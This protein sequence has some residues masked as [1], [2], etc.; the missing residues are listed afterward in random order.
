MNH[1][2]IMLLVEDRFSTCVLARARQWADGAGDRVVGL[3]VLDSLV[4]QSA[5]LQAPHPW[6][7]PATRACKRKQ[8]RVAAV[9]AARAA[10]RRSASSTLTLRYSCC[11]TRGGSF[12]RAPRAA[13]VSPRAHVGELT[14][15][16]LR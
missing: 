16:R 2:V 13:H 14:L 4:V 9:S 1:A 7:T 15:D 3:L 6:M 11:C 12:T 8:R 10:Q 5:R